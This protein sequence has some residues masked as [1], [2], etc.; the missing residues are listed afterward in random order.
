MGSEEGLKAFLIECANKMAAKADEIDE[1]GGYLTEI[2]KLMKEMAV[3]LVELE[4][5][6]KELEGK[7]EKHD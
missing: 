5:K 4:E 6:V 3:R 2:T 7:N 1:L